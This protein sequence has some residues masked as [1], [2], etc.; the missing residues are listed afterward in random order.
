MIIRSLNI[1]ISKHSPCQINTEDPVISARRV[2]HQDAGA[3]ESIVQFVID[4]H[5]L[6]ACRWWRW[7]PRWREPPGGLLAWSR[8][9]SSPLYSAQCR[10]ASLSSPPPLRGSSC[11]GGLTGRSMEQSWRRSAPVLV[12]RGHCCHT[13]KVRLSCKSPGKYFYLKLWASKTIKAF[14]HLIKIIYPNY[15]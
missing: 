8:T 3:K 10:S 9:P 13:L 7:R 12:C 6:T 2:A 5:L 14:K 4:C 1:T 11:C 15:F